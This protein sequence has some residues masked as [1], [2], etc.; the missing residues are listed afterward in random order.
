MKK[1]KVISSL[2]RGFNTEEFEA[3][4][5]FETTGTLYFYIS[6]ETLEKKIVK[7]FGLYNLV[8]VDV[9]G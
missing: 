7:V 3:S 8:C 6:T 1:Y 9:V 4:G 2:G 5:Y